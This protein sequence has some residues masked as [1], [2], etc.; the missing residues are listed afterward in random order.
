MDLPSS[1]ID[2][3]LSIVKSSDPKTVTDF[4]CE[5]LTLSPRWKY[6]I[7]NAKDRAKV[8]PHIVLAVVKWVSQHGG[9]DIWEYRIK[10]ANELIGVTAW[11]PPNIKVNIPFPTLVATAATSVSCL[12]PSGLQHLLK[13]VKKQEKFLKAHLS[14][15]QGWHLYYIAAST[16]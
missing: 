15:L 6:L 12:G 3:E 5:D 16:V 8:L 13:Y 11:L 7:P 4:L 9:G 10:P 2:V 14:H 1:L